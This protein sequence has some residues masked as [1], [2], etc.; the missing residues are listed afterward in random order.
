MSNINETQKIS[1]RLLVKACIEGLNGSDI[2]KLSQLFYR[3]LFH[4]DINL[5]SVFPGSISTLNRK[6]FSTLGILKDVRHLEKIRRSIEQL[7]ERHLLRYGAQIEYFDIV[8][9]ALIYALSEHMKDKLTDELKNAWI[10]VYDEVASIMKQAMMRVDQ[11]KIKRSYKDDNNYD[12]DFLDKIGGEEA[13]LRVHKRFYDVIF[14][15]PWLGQFFYGKSKETLIRK[16]TQFMVAAFNGPNNYLGDTPAFIHMHMFITDEMSDLRSKMLKQAIMAEG[17]SASI[18]DHWL[19]VDDAFRPS[20]VKKS[21]DECV[22]KCMGQ[23]P[24]TAKK[25]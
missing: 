18:A 23:L 10:S 6:F 15:D 4:L 9:Q 22:M 12:A 16:Q 8:E 13:I 19:Q 24:V 14:E 5:K 2:E 17:L 11:R 3:E 7:G 25:P 1:S 20:I 21:I